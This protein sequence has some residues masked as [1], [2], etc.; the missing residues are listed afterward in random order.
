M[1]KGFTLIE[2]LMSISIISIVSLILFKNLVVY[3]TLYNKE[4]NIAM[5]EF[6]VNEALIFIEQ[7]IN[8]A[9]SVQVLGDANN[10]ELKINY[11]D[12]SNYIKI[13]NGKLVIAYFK[14]DSGYINN[15]MLEL[16]DFL[17]EKSGNLVFVKIITKHGKEYERC[18]GIREEKDILLSILC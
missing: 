8:E 7:Q 17:V 6:Y 11:E 12:K 4:S 1:K 16:E 18:F 2:V 9:N 5:E 15:I 14:S 3:L 10:N 13:K